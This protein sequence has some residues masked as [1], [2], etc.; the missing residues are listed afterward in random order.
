MKHKNSVHKLLYL[1]LLLA[2]TAWIIT[3]HAQ[4]QNGWEELDHLNL[5]P[6]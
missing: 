4:D 3:T 2:G 1:F 5:K 6:K